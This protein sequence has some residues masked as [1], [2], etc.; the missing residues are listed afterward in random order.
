MMEENN[1][2]E[3]SKLRRKE[4]ERRRLK[5]RN[6]FFNAFSFL[7]EDVQFVF[8]RDKLDGLVYKFEAKNSVAGIVISFDY[9][10]LYVN[11]TIYKLLNG[12]I[13]DNSRDVFI[14]H[15]EFNGFCINHIVLFA[16]S[17]ELN[18]VYS[19]ISR[20]LINSD[21]DFQNYLVEIAAVTEKFCK[22]ILTG[23]FSSFGELDA[24]VKRRIINFI[25]I[26][27]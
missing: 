17:D 19:M 15:E 9:M 22:S 7:F 6:Q 3:L 11:V 21:V 4:H 8:I 14:N 2:H 18:K 26:D 24:F 12:K 16:K 10:D 23:D 13:V 25:S 27:Y 20:D 1:G 5:L